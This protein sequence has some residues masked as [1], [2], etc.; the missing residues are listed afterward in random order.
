MSNPLQQQVNTL[1]EDIRND[2]V[3]CQ[4]EIFE[5][6]IGGYQINR[7]PE[8]VFRAHFLMA[9]AG[10]PTDPNWV[11]KW[12]G[13]AGTPSAEVAIVDQQNNELF[14]VPPVIASTGVVLQGRSAGRM[15]DIFNHASDLSR[16]SPYQ[17]V[18]FMN[19]A[20]GTKTQEIGEAPE[21]HQRWREIFE[22]Y[23][24]AVPQIGDSPSDATAEQDGGD[25]FVY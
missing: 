13:I 11:A 15:K 12:I 21:S 3:R 18:Q 25:F 7:L 10:Q 19:Q 14:R 23:G 1:V 17:A 2:M 9:F 8:S 24:L 4:K 20:L 6:L 16:N 22:R 5:G